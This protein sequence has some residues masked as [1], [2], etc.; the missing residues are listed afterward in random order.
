VPRWVPIA[1]AAVLLAAVLAW[2][3]WR[4][5]AAPPAAGADTSAQAPAAAASAPA[6]T[7]AT[8]DTVQKAVSASGVP[9][10]LVRRVRLGVP[11]PPYGPAYEKLLPLA[12]GGDSAAQY[13]LGLLLYECRDVPEDDAGLAKQIEETY[14]TRRRNGWDVDDPAGEEKSLRRRHD[15]C[16]GVPQAERGNYRDY[17]RQAADSGLMQAELD[18]PLHL[19]DAQYCQYLSECTPEQRSMQEALQKEAVDYLGKARDAGSASALWT[20]GSWYA[21][22]DVLPQNNIEAYADFSALDQIFGAAGDERRFGGML[23]DLGNRLRPAD[24]AQA[25]ARAKEILSNP[26]CCV[27]T[28]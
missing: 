3:L 16:A 13:Q 21:E 11:D 12:K 28:Q 27:L 22:G 26:N 6:P 23:S 19:P 5:P 17:L 2:W 15:E 4:R 24:L 20:F 18:L 8:G 10:K 14:E 25:Q 1:V 7:A 9:I